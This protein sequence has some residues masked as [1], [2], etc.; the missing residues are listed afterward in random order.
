M[1]SE[2]SKSVTVVVTGACHGLH[3][4]STAAMPDMQAIACRRRRHSVMMLIQIEH[5]MSDDVSNLLQDKPRVC[6]PQNNSR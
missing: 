1:L 2:V 5:T 3:M 4:I 6:L